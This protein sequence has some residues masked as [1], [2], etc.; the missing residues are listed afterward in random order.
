MNPDG[1]PR[2][3]QFHDALR[4]ARTLLIWTGN[5]HGDV[6]IVARFVADY[7]GLEFSKIYGELRRNRF[8][9]RIRA[10]II[11]RGCLLCWERSA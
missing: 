6:Q 4:F 11:V 3:A 1:R 9:G 7:S 10:A 2:N 5:N 8:F